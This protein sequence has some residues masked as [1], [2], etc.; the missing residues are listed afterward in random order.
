[1]R[2]FLILGLLVSAFALGGCADSTA[3]AENTAPQIPE[4]VAPSEDFTFASEQEPADD[5]ERACMLQA[6]Q[7]LNELSYYGVAGVPMTEAPLALEEGLDIPAVGEEEQQEAYWEAHAALFGSV[8][9]I[10]FF[11]DTDA[12]LV[13]ISAAL[14]ET[15][16]LRARDL[17]NAY[18]RL[19]DYY[20]NRYLEATEPYKDD[21]AVYFEELEKY[22]VSFVEAY[23]ALDTYAEGD[24]G[25][26]YDTYDFTSELD[27][28]EQTLD[29]SGFK[30]AGP[31]GQLSWQ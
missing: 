7:T 22:K 25:S 2:I 16:P 14:A 24:I 1:M 30:P 21:L 19:L 15:D 31:N 13:I 5:W 23:K 29:V 6:V 11:V 4:M 28:L 3:E 18:A 8:M 10:A 27:N 9:D 20:A 17:G 26:I 12:H